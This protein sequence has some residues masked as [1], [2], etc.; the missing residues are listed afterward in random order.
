RA[1]DRVLVVGATN[2]PQELDEAARR[3]FVKRLYVPLPDKNGRR[4]LMNILL[5]T[6]PKDV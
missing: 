6:S 3:R 2:R 5:K 4:Q 1:S